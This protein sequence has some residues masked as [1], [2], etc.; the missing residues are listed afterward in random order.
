LEVGKG[1]PEEAAARLNRPA[2]AKELAS[3]LDDWARTR[4]RA[5]KKP[6]VPG[7]IWLITAAIALDNDPQRTTIRRAMLRD[8]RD[9]LLK[10][11]ADPASL[12]LPQGFWERPENLVAPHLIRSGNFQVA[13]PFAARS[14]RRVKSGRIGVRSPNISPRGRDMMSSATHPVLNRDREEI[15]VPSPLG[16]T[17]LQF[18]SRRGLRG[19][20][21]SDRGGDVITLQ[22]EPEMGRVAMAISDWEK[23][24]SA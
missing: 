10:L 19:D 4:I 9:A 18:L 15:R 20:L 24:N 2:I 22:G 8:D 21:R 16:E 13:P 5:A 7:W 11:M 17:L 1:A 23:T 14:N 12:K 6:D 3:A